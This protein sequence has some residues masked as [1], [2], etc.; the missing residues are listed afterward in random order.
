MNDHIIN[1]DYLFEVSWEV[2]NKVGGIYTV[3][4]T[5]ALH[6]RSQLGRHPIL[7]GP[8]GWMHRDPV[9]LASPALAGR[10]FTTSATWEALING[11]PSNWS[12]LP[13]QDSLGSNLL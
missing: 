6:L 11:I 13:L 4:A 7:I 3:V 10:F 12:Y 9:S 5:K 8:D 2:C 1:P